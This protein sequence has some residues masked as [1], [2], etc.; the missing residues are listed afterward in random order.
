MMDQYTP[1]ML[2]ELLDVS[3]ALVRQWHRR[4]WLRESAT[5]Q[6]LPYFDLTELFVA[7][8][9]AQLAKSGLSTAEIA[10]QLNALALQFPNVERPMATLELRIDGRD[11]F[12]LKQGSLVDTVG[13][14][15]FDFAD[16][17]S[18]DSF[19]D[20]QNQDVSL[21]DQA[22][23]LPEK[24]PV[25]G[26]H[27]SEPPD[28]DELCRLAYHCEEQGWIEQA[29]EFFRAAL[30]AGGADAALCFQLG[31]LLYRQG[32]KTAARERY[33][34]TIELDENFVE[35]RANLGCVLAET[36]ELELAVSAFQGAL[37]HHADY[38]DVYY[39]LGMTLRK[40]GKT[41]EAE[42]YLQRFCELMPNSP[43]TESLS[44]DS[45]DI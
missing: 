12:L 13:H 22:F 4:G 24:I 42:R 23:L 38:A 36:G 34:M 43:W 28:R 26:K 8:R 17:E 40:L 19:F 18:D 35:A 44:G 21:M 32:D 45:S 11:L 27:L 1:T 37:Q 10:K 15:L 30:A 25:P 9:L 2:A 33:Y 7:K 41:I 6:K 31:E 5:V 14:Q 29:I 39:H 16:A 20:G 3:A